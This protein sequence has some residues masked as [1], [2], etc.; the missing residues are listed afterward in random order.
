MLRYLEAFFRNRWIVSI[1][2]LL[3]LF[4]GAALVL[5]L[6]PQHSATATIWTDS[7]KY[8]EMNGENRFLSPAEIQSRRL[9]QLVRT[10]MLSEAIV[11]RVPTDLRAHV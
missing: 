2:A 10:S 3:L 4:A 9:W 7:V 11:N 1:P 8:L 5:A 6:P